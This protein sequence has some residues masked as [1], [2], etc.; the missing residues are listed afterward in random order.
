[1]SFV[2]NP[3]QNNASSNNNNKSAVNGAGGGGSA[4]APTPTNSDPNTTNVAAGE[5]EADLF[6]LRTFDIYWVDKYALM[7]KDGYGKVRKNDREWF[8][9]VIF[10]NMHTTV[11]L[12]HIPLFVSW[13]YRSLRPSIKNLARRLLL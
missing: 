5:G 13:L 7:Y 1:M 4:A 12:S 2:P 6:K 10:W 9:V 3:T 8:W 11:G